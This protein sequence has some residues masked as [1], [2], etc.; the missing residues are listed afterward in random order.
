MYHKIWSLRLDHDPTTPRTPVFPT[1]TNHSN[2][3]L[4]FLYSLLLLRLQRWNY[5]SILQRL[6]YD[7]TGISDPDS[8][9]RVKNSVRLGTPVTSVTV[10][11]TV[12]HFW[13]SGTDEPSG[14]RTRHPK[15][16]LDSVRTVESYVQGVT[17]DPRV[18][19]RTRPL[20]TSASGTQ[21]WTTDVN[22]TPR[23]ITTRSEL[24]IP[25]SRSDK[26]PSDLGSRWP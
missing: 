12:D 9:I 2:L 17:S 13:T 21:D 3:G 6:N 25:T 15:T 18:H 24:R 11:V 16:D 7:P 26:T 5:W 8:T 14:P 22:G 19:N 20:Q 1:G 23:W 10:G 4:K